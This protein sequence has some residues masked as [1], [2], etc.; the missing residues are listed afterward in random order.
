MSLLYLK[1]VCCAIIGVAIIAVTIIAAS[2]MISQ[3]NM[4]KKAE[5]NNVDKAEITIKNDGQKATDTY[6][7]V[8]ENF[9]NPDMKYAPY[10]FWF[11]DQDLKT[12]GIKPE[13]MA[14]ELS[15]KGFNPGYAHA[16]V[17]YAQIFGGGGSNVKALPVTQWLSAKWFEE[18]GKVAKQANSDGSYFSF[19]DEYAWPSFQAGGKI[20]KEN[21]DM[22]GK[23]LEFSTYDLQAGQ[24]IDLLSSFF[25]VAAKLVSTQ[26][27]SYVEYAGDGWQKIEFSGDT[28]KPAE[29]ASL[30]YN[31]AA[32]YVNS[33]SGNSYAIYHPYFT[34]TG[35]YKVYARWA[36]VVGNASNVVYQING[37]EQ[38]KVTVDQSKDI[39][40]WNVIGTYDFVQG[41]DSTIK[42]SDKANGK[43]CIDAIMYVNTDNEDDYIVIDELNTSNRNIGNIDSDTLE[44]IGTPNTTFTWNAP[45][46]GA[47]YRIY[48]FKL[49]VQR[50]YDGSP[51][52]YLDKSL[53]NKFVDIAY[54]PYKN[55]VVDFMGMG[56]TINGAFS[57]CEGAYGYK[58]A[59]SDDLAA[60]Y[61]QTTG[62]DIK[63][64]MPL[65][66]DRDIQ[67]KDAKARYDWYNV[68]S[69]IF[70]E[71]F[72][73]PANYAA[74]QGMY[75]TAHTWEESLQ[76]QASTV[77][78]YFKLTRN[79]TLPGT[80]SLTN[81][82]YNPQNFKETVS[83]AEFGNKRVMAEI[84]ALEGLDLYTPTE[85]KKQANY[86]STWGISHVVTHSLK[87]T[88]QLSQSVVTPDFYNIDPTWKD[89][90]LWTD[91]VRRT[92]YINSNGFNNAKVLLLNPMDSVWAL[93]EGD[94]ADQ[95]FKTFAE[96]SGIPMSNSSF[97][98]KVSEINRVYSES[99]RQLTANRIDHLVAD[100][101]YVNEMV[102]QKG[103]L[104]TGNYSFNAALLPP[105]T[106]IDTDVA[107]KLRTFA[108]NGGY[109]YYLGELPTGS[110]QN[111]RN[112]TNIKQI[113]S[114]IISL[115]TVEF[116]S[117]LGVALGDNYPYLTSPVEFVDGAFDM[118]MQYRIIDGRHFVWVANN[119]STQHQSKLY[120]P[121]ISGSVSI[122]NPE[123]GSMR[124]ADANKDRNG[125][126]I[127]VIFEPYEGYYIVIDTSEQISVGE[128]V[129]YGNVV[130]E[131]NSGWT[132]KIDTGNKQTTIS[133]D[134][135]P[136]TSGKIRMICRKGS[137]EDPQYVYINE[138]DVNN[139]T[140]IANSATVTVSSG[141]G[142]QNVNDGNL[143]TTWKNQKAIK[144]DESQYIELAFPISQTFNNI[145]IHTTEGKAIRSYRLE[146][147]DGSWWKNLITFNEAFEPE[148]INPITYPTQLTNGSMPVNLTDWKTWGVLNSKFSGF[149]D[150]ENTFTIPELSGKTYL[151]LDQVGEIAQIWINGVPAGSKIF[152]PFIF[153]ITDKVNTGSN[154]VKVRVGNTIAQNAGQNISK[155]GL[156]GSITIKNQFAIAPPKV[157]DAVPV[158][159]M[160]VAA[161]SA[162]VA[163][164]RKKRSI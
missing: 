45:N 37:I 36:N 70:A 57:D 42:V 137:F 10:E 55:N 152:A 77:G 9:N 25:T 99:I 161:T 60:T 75:Y 72:A 158:A 28:S 126:K 131:I 134:F 19:T 21:P 3:L 122:W 50:G 59:W 144:Y 150:Y 15:E 33:G 1:R 24:S 68:V 104:T 18:F 13:D 69:D 51:V 14:R 88:R 49:V 47:S 138:I 142:A 80:D 94:V 81:V 153:D 103:T 67:G 7:Q 74:E 121:N 157:F 12:L 115:K 92:S 16:R 71:N 76:L 17:N 61:N 27:S 118:L 20:L 58:L 86:I 93:S 97:G 124:T 53:G 145:T 113:M 90:K 148:L 162:V 107:L 73:S 163:V 79:F 23:S 26:K 62:Q 32:K 156:L 95:N 133:H 105:M 85:L 112:D 64:M 164:K 154:T 38:N 114:E 11:W 123:D 151:D 146:Y 56:K 5:L 87:M 65:M 96:N 117:D 43:V 40:K 160:T 30:P 6:I 100:K 29:T 147:W 149:I 78:D 128:N 83:I 101:Y 22:K 110:I 34:Q 52:N 127:N 129:N 130:T 46:S 41:G 31:M 139:G 48:S 141:D 108:K 109:I 84:M 44:I 119:D 106:V 54:K 159:V 111:G 89:M 35:S 155:W 140:N 135:A 143:E 4:A 116:I 2:I 39:N 125:I 102:E 63:K 82:A 136:V 91:F 98:G 132:A 66:I 120:I 8:K